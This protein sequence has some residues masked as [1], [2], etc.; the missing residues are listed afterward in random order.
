MMRGDI[1]VESLPGEGSTFSFTAC[2]G[3][4]RETRPSPQFRLPAVEDI[5]SDDSPGPGAGARALLVEDNYLNQRVAGEIL[6]AAGMVVMTV[7]NGLE[8]VQYL[9]HSVVDIVLMDV[10]MPVMDGF[11]ATR[12]IRQNP[13]LRELP[14]IAMTAHAMQGDRELCLQAGMDDYVTKPI[15]RS[16]FLAVL[17]KWLKKKAAPRGGGKEGAGSGVFPCPDSGALPRE[18]VLDLAEALERV[19]GNASLL[20]KILS[21]FRELYRDSVEQIR[22]E[23]DRGR[24]EDAIL[25]VHSL[26]GIAG[27]LSAKALYEAVSELEGA[28]RSDTGSGL[29]ALLS[30]LEERLTATLAFIDEAVNTGK[31]HV[32]QATAAGPE[33]EAVNTERA[34][35][36]QVNAAGPKAEVSGSPSPAGEVVPHSSGRLP[37]AVIAQLL[38]YLRENDPVGSENCLANLAS[39]LPANGKAIHLERIASCISNYD[40][41]EAARLVEELSH[42]CVVTPEGFNPGRDLF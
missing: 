11:E 38:G 18:R 24:Q 10:Q 19:S 23:L 40:F 28:M 12:S 17:G 35:V 41:K 25:K 36:T 8:A 7:N 13:A 5:V 22:G 34:C 15:D 4:A 26:K 16:R 29:D 14:I 37:P 9:Q 3:K 30:W 20:F 33:G 2:F 39:S 31:S 32:T 21:Q 6:K 42:P 1:K 27:N